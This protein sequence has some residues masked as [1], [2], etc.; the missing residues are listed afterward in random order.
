MSACALLTCARPLMVSGAFE[1][2]FFVTDARFAG[3]ATW[4]A[5]L[6]FPFGMALQ[7]QPASAGLHLCCAYNGRSD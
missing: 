3:F 5:G 6:G 4:D 7:T 1:T 2:A